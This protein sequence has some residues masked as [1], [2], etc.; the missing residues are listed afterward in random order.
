MIQQKRSS[1]TH[2]PVEE[3]TQSQFLSIQF[4]LKG[5]VILRYITSIQRK[6]VVVLKEDHRRRNWL[7]WST[8]NWK[9]WTMSCMWNSTIYRSYTFHMSFWK[10]Y[11]RIHIPMRWYLL[12][13]MN[14]VK[15]KEESNYEMIFI[16]IYYFK[17][18]MS[19]G[20]S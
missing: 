20:S 17:I 4:M 19:F 7:K 15:K 6:W 14:W 18:D 13:R 9:E 16:L 2:S 1:W 5:I 11:I 3:V 12:Y 8:G 10:V